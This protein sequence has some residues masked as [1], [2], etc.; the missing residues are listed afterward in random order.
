MAKKFNKKN[1]D[2]IVRAT[3]KIGNTIVTLVGK[4]SFEW[5]IVKEESNKTVILTFKER[6]SAINEFNKYKP[7]RNE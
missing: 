4:H 1:C 7:F 6:T 3:L 5:S 2:N